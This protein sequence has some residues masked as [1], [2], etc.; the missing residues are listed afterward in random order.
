[1]DVPLAADSGSSL[2]K[3]CAVGSYGCGNRKVWQLGDVGRYPPRLVL[4]PR[5][6]RKIEDLPRS[7]DH[8]AAG[9]WATCK[10][11]RFRRIGVG[12]IGV[13]PRRT[14]IAVNGGA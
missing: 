1:M 13:A 12:R 6:L 3:R 2:A 10:D 7:I 8:S 9:S 11:A 14:G 5:T 4:P